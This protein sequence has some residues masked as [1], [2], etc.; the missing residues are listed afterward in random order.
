VREGSQSFTINCSQWTTGLYF[1]HLTIN[2]AVVTER[3]LI[4]R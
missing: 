1:V 4:N 3:V 2:D